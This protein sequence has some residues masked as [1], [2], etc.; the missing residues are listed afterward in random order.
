[1]KRA[2]KYDGI[3]LGSASG[4][5]ITPIEISDVK[6]Y[7]LKHRKSPEPFDI[8]FYGKTPLSK[9]T[10]QKIVTPYDNAGITWWIES[11]DRSFEDHV[12]RIKYGPK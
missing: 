6:K 4:K 8:A 11:N 7:I 9:N 10:I 1:M 3:Y 12:K 2:A 5:D